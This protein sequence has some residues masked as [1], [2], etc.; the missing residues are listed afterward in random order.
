MGPR[1]VYL[2]LLLWSAASAQ[3][4]LT[5]V[6]AASGKVFVSPGSAV[7]AFGSPLAPVPAFANSLP[8]PTVLA[9]LHIEVT[10]S[11]GTVRTAA[12]IM[13]SPTQANFI[14]PPATQPGSANVAL[15]NGPIP[16]GLGNVVVQIPAPGIFTAEG[17][18][19]GVAAAIAI[20]GPNSYPVFQCDPF[21]QICTAVP[22]TLGV[23]TP[24]CLALF[25]T[26]IRLGQILTVA[27]AGQVV[28][29]LYAGPQGGFPGLDQINV[30]IPL[31]LHNAGL[32]SVVVNVDGQLSNRV[33]ILIQ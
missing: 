5:V 11:F 30:T 2:P 22:V 14:L 10:D 25:G 4:S 29:W 16:V 12:M 8:L 24:V 20:Q 1:T 33:Q 31:T 26:G 3:T 13:V 28:P 18:G 9:G 7:A 15:L 17:D 6:S 27:I 23:D 32:V 21:F 19:L